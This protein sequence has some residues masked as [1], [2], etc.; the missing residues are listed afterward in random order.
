MVPLPLPLVLRFTAMPTFAGKLPLPLATR[1]IQAAPAVLVMLSVAMAAALS[2]GVTRLLPGPAAR[3][4]R[5]TTLDQ[6]PLTLMSAAQAP[7]PA[8]QRHRKQGHELR[9]V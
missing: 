4:L 7:P 5:L 1:T 6:L 9:M 3:S 8:S 2:I